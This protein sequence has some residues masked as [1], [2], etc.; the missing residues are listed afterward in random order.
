MRLFYCSKCGKNKIN[1]WL[2]VFV[3]LICKSAFFEINKKLAFFVKHISFFLKRIFHFILHLPSRFSFQVLAAE[4]AAGFPLQSGLA[5]IVYLFI[6]LFC[7]DCFLSSKNAFYLLF[8]MPQ[9][10]QRNKIYMNVIYFFDSF[11]LI[12]PRP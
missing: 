9:S 3:F 6:W 10:Q 1:L 12:I 7:T 2:C 4:A 8:Q 5:F 11:F